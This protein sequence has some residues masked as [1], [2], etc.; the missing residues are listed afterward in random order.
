M[1][2]L[3]YVKIKSMP[4]REKFV[5]L[6]I[7]S[8]YSLLD[9]ACRISD[10]L[11][12]A[13]ELRLPALALTDH[14]YM[15]AAIKF[16][17]QAK[18]VGIKPILGCE[19]YVAPR[20][21]FDKE[22]KEDR[23]PFHLTVLAKNQVGYKN[24]LKL[25]TLASLEGFYSRPRID[26]QLLEK[27]REGLVVLSGCPEGEVPTLL[28]QGKIE[29]AQKAAQWHREL[30]GDDYYLEI[31]DLGLPEFKNLCLL[32]SEL[33]K[34]TG[35]PLVATNDV[36]CVRREDAYAQDVMLA[37]QTNSYLDDEKRLRF[38]TDQFYLKSGAEM[39]ELFSDLPEA[40]KNTHEIAEKCNLELE[41]G[42]LHLPHFTVPGGQTPETFLEKLVWE[43]I[44]QKYGALL[45]PEIIDRV[46][47]ELYT[48]EKMGYAAY[49]LIVQDF[50]NWAKDQGI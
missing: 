49:F 12:R 24:L 14:G 4:H 37:I 48:I 38:N 31:M 26:R 36:H 25:A 13:K 32:M 33:S 42:V 34:K 2:A 46:K 8:E 10:L 39:A 20:T 5:H 29:E 19:F 9:G 17:V 44:K 18:E 21:R 6:H 45:P 16:Y 47:Y 11:E 22:T 28:L 50:I 7:H 27:Y 3:F 35:I 43:G 41:I 30:F 23:S 40:I 1:I 15:Y